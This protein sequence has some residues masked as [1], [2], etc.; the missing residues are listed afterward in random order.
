V[1]KAGLGSSPVVQVHVDSTALHAFD[2]L[3]NTGRSGL[4]VVGKDE[5]IVTQTSVTDLKLWLKTPSTA[6]LNQSIMKFLQLV[7]EQDINI[8]VPVLSCVEKDT[9][10]FVILKLDATRSHRIYVVDSHFHPVKVV[11]LTDIIALAFDFQP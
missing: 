3:D 11:S 5:T 1:S 8:Q 2:L 6:L 10:E 4:A 7:R 9:L